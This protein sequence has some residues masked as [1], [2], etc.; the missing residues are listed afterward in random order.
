VSRALLVFWPVRLA[1]V[2]T[3]GGVVCFVV[4]RH[5]T[6]PIVSV[7]RA[8][9]AL[10]DGRLQTRVGAAEAKRHD[11]LGA[12]ARDFDRMAERIEALVG[13]Q[14]RLLGDVSHELRSPLARMT[15]ALSLARQRA[16]PA[17]GEYF[18]RIDQ[19][20]GRLDR[21][22]EQLLTLARIETG[23]DAEPR[24]DFDLAGIVQDVVGDGDFEARASGRRVE[25]VRCAAASIAG[26][27][28]LMRSAIENVVRNAIRHTASGTAVDVSLDVDEQA[29]A[30]VT[31]RDRGRG[32]DEGMAADMF[33]PFWRAPGSDEA[34]SEGAGLGLAITDRIVAMHHG[35]VRATNANGSG[36][37]VTIELPLAG[38]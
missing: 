23:A 3:I 2:L 31:V 33:R 34:A 21:L 28:E 1:V 20:T 11:E 16:T 10:A 30:R 7:S 19:E 25:L 32:V 4:A 29:S 35:R 24:G 13:G 6:K 15:V 27:P 9:N 17:A 26:M 18:D 5:L 22:I 37:V 14:R 38:G 36:L 12:L 8:A